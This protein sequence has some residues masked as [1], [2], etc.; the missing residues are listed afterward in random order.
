MKYIDE[1]RNSPHFIS[2]AEAIKRKCS[3]PCA[4][5]EICGG[6]THSIAKYQLESLLPES[7]ELIHGP[8]CPVCVTPIEKIDLAVELSLRPNFIV[9]SFGDMMRVPGSEL[10]LLSAKARGADIS[11]VYSP[12]DALALAQKHPDKE[13]VFLAIGFETTAPLHAL[14][15]KEA[16]R[17]GVRN[18]SLLTSLFTVPAALSSL[19]GDKDN[20]VNALLAAGHVCAVT[21]YGQYFRIARHFKTPIVVTGFE[22]MDILY[23]IY[24]ALCLLEEKNYTVVNGYKRIVSAEGN[25][26]AQEAINEV[27]EFCDNEWRGLG[28][29][30]QSGLKIRD[31]YQQFDALYRFK[32]ERNIR[33]AAPVCISGAIMKGLSHPYRCDQFGKGC[34]PEHP[35]GAPMVSSEGVCAAYYRYMK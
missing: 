21:G 26:K 31:S 15:I 30:D 12:L 29:I 32:T 35:L 5:M 10:S 2:L 8:G 13:I 9:A 34:V 14:V 3:R 19:L 11:I 4:I 1:Y 27:F 28:Y 7:I 16:Q 17:R 24:H 20:R 6:Q 33:K 18:F 22:P 25:T 23:G